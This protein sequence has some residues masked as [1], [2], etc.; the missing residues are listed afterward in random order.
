MLSDA[1]EA[2]R[3][4]RKIKLCQAGGIRRTNY[5]VH[6]A[7]QHVLQ[8]EENDGIITVVAGTIRRKSWH[9]LQL[10]LGLAP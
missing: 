6:N 2:L 9:L 1:A 7:F 5:C 10:V 4:P 8:A 3:L